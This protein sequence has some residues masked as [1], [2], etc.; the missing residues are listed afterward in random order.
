MSNLR[1]PEQV[2]TRQNNTVAFNQLAVKVEMDSVANAEYYAWLDRRRADVARRI[3]G[4]EI[5]EKPTARS[6]PPL[7]TAIYY[8]TSDYQLLPTGS[9]LRTSCR[10]DTHAFCAFKLAQDEHGVR[11]DLRY[12]FEGEEKKTIQMA[13]ASPEAVAIVRRLL[14]RADI[15]HPGTCLEEYYGIKAEVLSPAI[16]LEDY[17]SH[18]FVWLDKKDALRC[19]IDRAWVR[20]LRL[21]EEAQSKLPV[22][23]VEIA[24]YPRIDPEVA[25]DRRVIRLIEFLSNSLCQEFNV[26]ITTDIKYQRAAQVLGIHPAK[27]HA[28]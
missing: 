4:A 19:S 21:P 1:M 2:Y 9:L 26:R 7:N 6:S 27:S 8:D 28:I 15:R 3:E 23:E 12:V 5:A 18:F 22:S 16:C 20:N 17:R 11:G 24:I 14:A 13:P 10:I 25:R